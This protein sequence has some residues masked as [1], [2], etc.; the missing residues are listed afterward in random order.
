MT[1]SAITI[2]LIAML[3]IWGGLLLSS[4]HLVKNPDIPLESVPDDL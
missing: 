3:L 1:M 2:M 4:I